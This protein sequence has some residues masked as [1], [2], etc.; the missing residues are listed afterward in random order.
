[1]TT[2]TA[3]AATPRQPYKGSFSFS[4]M[5]YS[6]ETK[7]K[8]KQK[9]IQYLQE[10]PTAT[11]IEIRK[12]TGIHTERIF[13][14]GIQEMYLEADIPCPVRCLKRSREEQK[15]EVIKFIQL[16][17]GCTVTHIQKA[18]RVTIS[19]IFGT[20]KN[21]Y[22][23]A[24][25]N[26]ECTGNTSLR[27]PLSQKRQETKDYIL[28]NPLASSNEISKDMHIKFHK[29]FSSMAELYAETGLKS[30]NGTQKRTLKIQQKI[31]E[32][33]QNHPTA[34]QWEINTVC[35]T[36]VQ[37]EF[38][39]GI[40][41]AYEKAGVKYP[42]ERRKIYG[43]AKKEIKERAAE[44]EK[45][46]ITLLEK[47]GKV[48]KQYSTDAGRLDALFVE[49]DTTYVVEIKDYHTKQISQSEL[50]QLDRYI[51]SVPNCNS[52][53]LITHKKAKGRKNKVY[54]GKN[55]ISIVAEEDLSSLPLLR[56]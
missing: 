51:Q 15:G 17:P 55:R 38:N 9:V 42:E 37:T 1:M 46:V 27:R 56:D 53:L 3:L 49:N 40:R 28:R 22:E 16:H 48:C 14:G 4:Y 30:I 45:K 19:R 12:N 11:G 34:S 31:I 21:A 32:Y 25:I 35:K 23:Q 43:A 6:E 7:K 8:Y 20:I 41:E 2:W 36:K 5:S 18:T 26:Y 24:N 44:F 54:I 47:R 13:E 39:M 29:C 52:G 50:K 33:I 10:H